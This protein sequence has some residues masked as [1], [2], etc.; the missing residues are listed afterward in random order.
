M[1]EV[2]RQEPPG[3][4][5][6][7]NGACVRLAALQGGR[8]VLSLLTGVDRRFVRLTGESQGWFSDLEGEGGAD[9]AQA[10]FAEAAAYQRGQGME[11]L[12]GPGVPDARFRPGLPVEGAGAF[13]RLNRLLLD[14]GF[15]ILREYS[16]F[17]V[18]PGALPGLRRAAGRARRLHGVTTRRMGFTK[19]SCRAV[20]ELYEPRRVSFEEFSA[21]LDGMRPL[22]IFIAAVRGVDVGF[23]LLVWE[24]SAERV[25]TVMVSPRFRGGPALL[26]LLDAL[27]ECA[28]QEVFT[29]AINRGNAP[30]M[31]LAHALGGEPC[32]LWREYV[33]YLI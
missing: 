8:P 31:A 22:E 2:V 27:G 32:G 18:Q 28:G 10:L 30:S 17:R 12:I 21:V 6:R 24:G 15:E 23:A 3:R 20:Y 11:R 16:A 33:L 1:I 19:S 13:P 4:A 25:E 9:A 14:N 5:F 29:G 7:H 26:C